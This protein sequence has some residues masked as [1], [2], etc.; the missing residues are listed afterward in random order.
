MTP[1]DSDVKRLAADLTARRIDRREFLHRAAAVGLSI[2]AAAALLAACGGGGGGGGAGETAGAPSAAETGLAGVTPTGQAAETADKLNVRIV[3]DIANLDPAFYPTSEDSQIAYCIME[4]LVT[5]KPGTFDVT[6]QLAETFTPSSDGL[7]YAFK[8]KQGIQ[9]QGGYGE[10]TADDV[11]FSYERIAGLTKPNLNSPYSGDW[12]PALKEVKVKDKY[13]GTIILKEP[14]AAIM[15]STLPVGSG[16]VLSRKAVTERGDKYPTAPIGTGP[17][18]FSKWTP[19]QKVVL[20]RFADYGGASNDF[21]GTQFDEL[22]FTPIA[23]DNAADIALQTGSVD[24]GQV[25][26]KGIDRFAADS[27][28]TVYKQATLNFNWIGMNMR[29]PKL[30]DIRVR[31]AIRL[32]VDVPAIL[33]AAFEGK[34]TRATAIIPPNM[35]LGYWKDAP[36]YDRDVDQAKGLLTDAGVSGLDLSFMYTEQT[37][38]K[39]LA[40][41]VQSNLADIG[42]K[43]TLNQV[44][45]GTFYTLGKSLRQRELFYVGY[46]TEPDP[47]WSVVWFICKQ[48]DVW[49]WMYWCDKEFDRLHFAA[50]R[51]LDPAKRDT[52]YVQ[53]Q[54]L[55]DQAAHTIW[56]YW[57]TNYFGSR[58]AVQASLYPTGYWYVPAFTVSA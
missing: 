4:G 42:I 38:S 35:G 27:D 19:K 37:G 33:E 17:Y 34:M 57:P 36:V 11:K 55:W 39:D 54:K 23:D 30:T 53:M 26:L 12:S 31:K 3:N 40:Q 10:V 46:V 20:K 58:K 47:S 28:F 7:S 29:H 49:N 56:I 45:A 43:V 52:M 18:E 32:A 21:L 48:I 14:F 15:R 9:F 44:D 22:N 13:S 25:S 8:L 1:F 5:Y 41:I 6:N 2:P 50:L 51:E 24:F 16:W